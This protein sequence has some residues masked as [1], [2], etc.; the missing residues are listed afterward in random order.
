MS[1]K[2]AKRDKNAR[3]Y[4]KGYIA[5]NQGRSKD[6][7]PFSDGTSHRESWVTGWRVGRED[8][9]SGY[10]NTRNQRQAMREA[11]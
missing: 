7:C 11:I 1:T 3:A 4:A 5:G 10:A 8:L 6:L 2:R 9:W